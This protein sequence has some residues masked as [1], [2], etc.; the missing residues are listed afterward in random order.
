MALYPSCLALA[1]S[2]VMIDTNVSSWG[3]CLTQSVGMNDPVFM[4]VF[5]ML[6]FM[7]IL[8]MGRQNLTVSAMLIFGLSSVYYMITLDSLFLVFNA[9]IVIG[10]M[11]MAIKGFKIHAQ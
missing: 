4:G 6:G 1:D 9:L 3:Q 5:V 10:S 2:N 11:V 7:I 8:L